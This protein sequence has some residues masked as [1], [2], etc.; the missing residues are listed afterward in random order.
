MWLIFANDSYRPTEI[1]FGQKICNVMFFEY[2]NPPK[3]EGIKVRPTM[4]A[5]AP[6]F[7]SISDAST[8]EE[9]QDKL[10]FGVSSVVKYFRPKVHRHSLRLKSLEKFKNSLITGIAGIAL[11]ILAGIIIWLITG[12]P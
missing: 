11:G 2:E 10:G 9:I 8:V 6:L 7:P 1:F 4:I 3:I 12:K 5:A